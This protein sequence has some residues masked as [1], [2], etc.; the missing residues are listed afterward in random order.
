MSTSF[1]VA[2]QSPRYPELMKF[3]PDTSGQTAG[4]V[5]L[6][7][8]LAMFT[9]VAGVMTFIFL[10]AGPLALVPA[11]IALLGAYGF[12]HVLS[13]L[14]RFRAAPVERLLAAV[15]DE[16]VETTVETVRET[17]RHHG[18]RH[19]RTRTRVRHE[20]HL[21]LELRDGQRQSHEVDAD[22]ARVVVKGDVG[23][24]YLKAGV[25][26]DFKPL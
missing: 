4:M 11:L 26:I 15:R 9:G 8:F 24:A 3:T 6:L 20:H 25:L 22:L 10:I 16:T 2:E 12:V 17:E 7:V 19:Q 21:L 18:H 13:K 23:V 1:E 14:I 5:I